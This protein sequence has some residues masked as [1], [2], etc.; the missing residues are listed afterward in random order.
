MS[1]AAKVVIADL[2]S[3]NGKDAAASIGAMFSPTDVTSEADVSAAL[4]MLE[5]FGGAPVN[6]V[7]NCAGVSTMCMFM[8]TVSVVI[9]NHKSGFV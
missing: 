2:S 4:D 3:S 8:C 5:K 7:V 1:T 9:I 6:A